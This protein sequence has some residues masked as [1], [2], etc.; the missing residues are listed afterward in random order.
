MNYKKA[1]VTG[2]VSAVLYVT[3]QYVT[4]LLIVIFSLFEESWFLVTY[5]PGILA[6]S[7]VFLCFIISFG[8]DVLH[9][10]FGTKAV[11]VTGG[12]IFISWMFLHYMDSY[13]SRTI[14]SERISADWLKYILIIFFGSV[15]GPALEEVVYRGYIFQAALD[16]YGVFFA[17]I[18]NLIL[19]A[20][21]H[22]SRSI[23]YSM[24]LIVFWFGG[25]LIVTVVY[26]VAKIPASIIVHGFMN[27][28][29]LLLKG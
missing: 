18:I 19:F 3:V 25:L 23:Q 15:L 9:V 1:L 22:A 12:G 27:M 28:Y 10:G 8:V 24:P 26:Q 21:T 11:F 17:W 7:V 14:L 6:L 2:I 4:M 29:I 16:K 20:L 13:S 5:V